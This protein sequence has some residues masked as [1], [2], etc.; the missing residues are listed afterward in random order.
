MEVPVQSLRGMT[1]CPLEKR[2]DQELVCVQAVKAMV[3][4][5]RI[6]GSMAC[7]N[8]TARVDPIIL[9]GGSTKA[10]RADG[11][12]LIHYLGVLVILK[13]SINMLTHRTIRRTLSI[14]VDLLHAFRSL[15]VSVSDRRH[16]S[17]QFRRQRT[18]GRSSEIR[19]WATYHL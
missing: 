6:G 18:A 8:A 2:L 10:W 13:A 5:T 12:V 17:S 7:W 11:P 4:A 3:Q 1:T 16:T 9:G 19:F 14:R 15:V